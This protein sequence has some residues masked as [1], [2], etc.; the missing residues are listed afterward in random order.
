MRF[1]VPARFFF[2]LLALA[3]LG[4][5]AFAR[6]GSDYTQFGH[7]IR[8]EADQK[9]G[10]VTC[11]ACSVYVRGQ[12]SGDITTFGGN[13]I[14]EDGGMIAG[15]VTAFA[16]DVRAGDNTKIAG[17]VSIFGGRLRRQPTAMVA[18]E[19][20]IFQSALWIYLIFLSPFLMFAAIVALVIWL[21]RRVRRPAPAMARVA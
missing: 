2:A 19:V 7:T 17:D 3:L 6:G 18:G 14:L 13:V 8:V 9:A 20:T 4:S 16:G 21:V 10:E 11:F 5:Q 15:E 1:V 12:V